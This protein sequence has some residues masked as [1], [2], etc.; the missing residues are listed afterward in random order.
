M[1]SWREVNSSIPD[2][3]IG[4]V[5][6]GGGYSTNFDT[7]AITQSWASKEGSSGVLEGFFT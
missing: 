7:M 2:K 3:V 5:K 6:E 1:I 4:G